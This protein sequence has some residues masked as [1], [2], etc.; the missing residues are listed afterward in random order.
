MMAAAGAAGDKT[1]V[2]DV[3]STQLWTGNSSSPRTITTGFDMA[4][5]GGLVWNIKRN[6]ATESDCSIGG[7]GLRDNNY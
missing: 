7:T 5:D 1:Y 6:S 2:D 4:S 3:F